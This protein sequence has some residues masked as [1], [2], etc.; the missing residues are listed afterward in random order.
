MKKKFVF[1]NY[2]WYFWAKTKTMRTIKFRAWDGEK[3]TP[4]FYIGSYLSMNY[5]GKL[6]QYTG[7][8]DK[9][10]KEIYEGDILYVEY[11][12]SRYLNNFD[13]YLNKRYHVVEWKGQGFNV[14]DIDGDFRQSLCTAI[15]NRDKETPKWEVIGNIYETPELIK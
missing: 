6:M 14:P 8:K 3:M 5:T 9:N 10:G 12:K 4:E 1:L 15:H 11:E 7:L 13:I 2:W